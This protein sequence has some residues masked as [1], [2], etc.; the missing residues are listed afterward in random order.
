M[1]DGRSERESLQASLDEIEGLQK[2]L[3]GG[4]ICYPSDL[5][6]VR[7]KLKRLINNE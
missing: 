1:T 5:E 7:L 6:G 4:E 2:A 3:E